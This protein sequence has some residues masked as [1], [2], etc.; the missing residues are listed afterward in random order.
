MTLKEIISISGKPSLYKMVAGNRMPFI[1][2]DIKNGR[3]QPVFA[4]EKVLSLADISMYTEEGD[5]PLGEVFENIKTVYANQELDEATI[6]SNEPEL[7][8]FI[9]KVLPNYRKDLVHTSDIKKLVKWYCM[10]TAAGMTTFVEP[11]ETEKTEA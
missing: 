9:E 10:L 8:N 5:K 4:R 6:I 11:T 1:V 2:E 7:R 3:K